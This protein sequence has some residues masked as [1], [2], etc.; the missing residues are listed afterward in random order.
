MYKIKISNLIETHNKLNESKLT[1][2]QTFAMS[3]QVRVNY[4]E[5]PIHTHCPYP[6][7]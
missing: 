4:Q 1:S 3:H 5:D 7:Q 6:H 2:L